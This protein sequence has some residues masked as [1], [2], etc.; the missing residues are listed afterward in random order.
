MNS[1]IISYL[2]IILIKSSFEFIDTSK[3]NE[4]CN[5]NSD[6]V[7]LDLMGRMDQ[8][9]NIS[10]VL[11]IEEINYK[12]EKKPVIDS[13][14]VDLKNGESYSYLETYL[15]KEGYIKIKLLSTNETITYTPEK[16]VFKIA[17][18][19]TI[20]GTNADLEAQIYHKSN[21]IRSEVYNTLIISLLMTIDDDNE[22]TQDSFFNPFL[23]FINIINNNTSGNL[24]KDTIFYEDISNT[25]YE[26][27]DLNKYVSIYNSYFHYNGLISNPLDSCSTYSEIL[28]SG[29]IFDL[30]KY[31]YD[32]LFNK[33]KN[34][35]PFGNNKKSLVFEDQEEIEDNIF[36]RDV[37]IVYNK[38]INIHSIL[39][40]DIISFSLKVEFFFIIITL[41]FYT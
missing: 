12:I 24:E 29:N 2:S 28:V 8:F 26:E 30:K 9:Y 23:N 13:V 25:K 4:K 22:D 39:N 1:I 38:D 5:L 27:F 17:S 37:H 15:N 36:S 32:Y 21:V 41:I 11:T 19:H 3:W 10:D 34:Y 31:Q 35:H 18:E 14:T 16:I 33:I 20:D 6:Y 40:F 7:P